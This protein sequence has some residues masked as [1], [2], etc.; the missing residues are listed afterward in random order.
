MMIAFLHYAIRSETLPI[1]EKAWKSQ[2]LKP[3]EI[4]SGYRGL[5]LQVDDIALYIMEHYG[6]GKD[7]ERVEDK[8]EAAMKKLEKL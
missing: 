1:K 7:T 4:T 5:D 6:E 8:V 2:G 3:D